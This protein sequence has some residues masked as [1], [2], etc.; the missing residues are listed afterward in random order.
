MAVSTRGRSARTNWPSGSTRLASPIPISSFAPQE[1]CGSRTSCSG[2]R[3]MPSSCSCLCCGLISTTRPSSPRSTNTRRG[4]VVL[5]LLSNPPR[6]SRRREDG[7]VAVSGGDPAVRPAP[8]RRFGPDLK[9][10]VAAAV[11][12][13]GLALATAWIGG[14]I[15]AAFWWLAALVVLWEWQRLIGG[16]RLAERLA[17]GGLFIALAGVFALHN[18][19]PGVIAGLILG[20]AA[21]GARAGRETGTWAGVGVLYAG[22]LVASVTLLRISP[23]YGLAAILWVFAVVWGADIAAYFAGR[24]IGGPQL[25]AR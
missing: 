7:C 23:S 1:K 12:M 18:S 9:P 21:V 16:A 3:P 6:S 11:A 5:A 25:W 2:R 22:A 4:N 20:A 17:L 24:V 19:I 10:R 13:G 15:F 8:R 14:F